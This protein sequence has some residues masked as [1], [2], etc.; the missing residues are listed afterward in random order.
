MLAELE[1]RAVPEHPGAVVAVTDGAP[2]IQ[3]V[4]DLHC[5]YAVGYLAEAAKATRGPGTDAT[6]EWLAAQRTALKRGQTDAVLAALAAVPLSDARATAQRY[7]AA[8]RAM[9]AYDQ[10]T[11]ASWPIGSGAVE[12]ANKVVVEARLKGTG[13]HWWREHADALV[14]LRALHASG[15]WGAAWPRIAA[16]WSGTRTRRT[17]HGASPACSAPQPP[18]PMLDQPPTPAR[19][20]AK[21]IVNARPTDDHPW[22][23]VRFTPPHPR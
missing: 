15:R 6:S 9:L 1:R 19:Q 16:A 21:T 7:L 22:K 17:I 5:P 18:D 12:S 8:R 11:A 14:G 3:E 13:M 10:F 20:R 4:L 23:R 2:W